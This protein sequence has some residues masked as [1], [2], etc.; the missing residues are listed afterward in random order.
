MSGAASLWTE[1]LS[2]GPCRPLEPF[3]PTQFNVHVARAV[4]MNADDKQGRRE[5]PLK[6]SRR[7]LPTASA[8]FGAEFAADILQRPRAGAVSVEG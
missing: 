5:D 1:I 4:S 7:P 2:D 8:I 6:D 3:R